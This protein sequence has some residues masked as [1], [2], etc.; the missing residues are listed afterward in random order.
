MDQQATWLENQALQ[1]RLKMS[2]LDA[3]PCAED[4]NY[5]HAR[6]PEGT[7]F[8]ALLQQSNGW[9]SIRRCWSLGPPGSAEVGFRDLL[10]AQ[11]GGSLSRHLPTLTK[12]D[13]LRVDDFA[14]SPTGIPNRACFW[15]SAMTA[16]GGARRCSPASC[17]LSKWHKQIGDSTIADSILD[18]LV[19][20]AYRFELSGE[21][22][23]KPSG[24]RS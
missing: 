6:Q 24:G 2:R 13:V 17:R 20:Q 7:Q 23:R 15:R 10:Q 11:A 9:H 16:T 18:R 5:R 22:L 4:V 12:L 21:S 1:R 3:E 14:M 19:H 8:R